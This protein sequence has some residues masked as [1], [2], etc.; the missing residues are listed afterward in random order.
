MIH[1]TRSPRRIATAGAMA[2][3]VVTAIATGCA[4][5]RDSSGGS[6]VS[7]ESGALPVT[8]EHRYGTTTISRAPA[9]VAALGAGDADTLLALGIVPTTMVP[10]TDPAAARI[11]E[12]WNEKLLG[13]SRPVILGQA[14]SDLGSVLPAALATDPDLVIAMNNAVSRGQY[15]TLSKVAP[16]VVRPAQAQDWQIPWATQASEIG[17]AVG[18]PAEAAQLVRATEQVFTDAVAAHPQLRG[19]TGA[20]VT[21]SAD[22]GVSIYSPGDGRGQMLSALGL[23]FPTTLQGTLTNGFY[24]SISAENLGLLGSLDKLVVVDWQGS[25]DRLRA[26]P[27]F[28]ALD[29]VTR[30]DVVFLDTQAGSAMS[31]PTVLTIP[32]VA[33]KL[34]PGLAS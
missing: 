14:S 28:A 20:V 7:I 6:A 12:P 16:T 21:A 9:R 1:R 5:P 31:V 4:A 30:G 10:F 3:V 19:R 25:S 11:V 27:A 24:G 18:K 22:G 8:V 17:K 2:A 15:D 13:S 26:N 32:W 23:T 34:V 29:V 33:A